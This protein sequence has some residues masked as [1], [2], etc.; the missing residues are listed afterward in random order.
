MGKDREHHH[1]PECGKRPVVAADDV[2]VC[3]LRIFP[4]VEAED[5][6]L[7]RSSAP[8]E[9]ESKYQKSDQE[10]DLGPGELKFRFSAEADRYEILNR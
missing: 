10:D 7:L 9:D 2:G 1:L 8:E 6:M 5:A 4:I 3:G